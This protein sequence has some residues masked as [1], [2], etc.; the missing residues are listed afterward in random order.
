[1]L[2]QEMN[3][4]SLFIAKNNIFTAVF[5]LSLLFTAGRLINSLGPLLAFEINRTPTV[6]LISKN[7][8]IFLLLNL[9]N[10]FSLSS[11]KYTHFR[12]NAYRNSGENLLPAVH[13][14]L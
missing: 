3:N 2:D 6:R 12:P 9:R 4:Y 7:A 13:M 11:L 10:I 1:M 5:F 8:A 14:L